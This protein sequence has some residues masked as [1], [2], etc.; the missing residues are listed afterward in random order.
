MLAS[1][2]EYY[3]RQQRLTL[4][5]IIRAAKAKGGGSAEVAKVV[6]A[7]QV[8]AVREAAAAL[9]NMLDEQRIDI[10]PVGRVV[11]I[12]L[13]GST[14]AGF[15]MQT[16]FQQ[17]TSDAVFDMIVATQLQDVARNMV[18][19]GVAARPRMGYVRQISAG[20]CSRCAVLAGRFYRW[21]DGFL[22]HPRCNCKNIPAREGDSVSD[23]TMTRDEYFRGL[24]TAEQDRVFSKAGAQA[25]RDGADMSQVVN[26]YR[27]SAGMQFAQVSPVKLKDGLKFT[28]EGTTKYG[29]AGQAQL[30]LRQNGPQQMRPMP[31]TIYQRAG[32]D[33]AMA[34]RMLK[35]YGYVL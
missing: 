23:I 26:V 33:R 31:E 6:A 1:A 16:V 29:V 8:L 2:T 9:D 34:M 19:L 15:P 30:R 35:L 28:T 14:S 18:G 24:S 22:R 5:A 25:L 13:V 20:A 12:S 10:A 11:P 32:D 7:F 3:T 27:R 4:A 21:S 17:P